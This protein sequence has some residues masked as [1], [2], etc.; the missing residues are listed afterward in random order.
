MGKEEGIRKKLHRS[1]SQT[2]SG[3]TA[4][5][6]TTTATTMRRRNHS[7]ASTDAATRLRGLFQTTS[8]PTVSLEATRHHHLNCNS[9]NP[10]DSI[11]PPK[12]YLTVSLNP[13]I[14]ATNAIGHPH[15]VVH[16]R[17]TENS[18]DPDLQLRPLTSGCN[19]QIGSNFC[20]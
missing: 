2:G 6:T 16:R 8:L 1:I 7:D 13:A 18:T 15:I 14:H 19:I 9:P 4:K 3:P 17:S 12:I 20:L 10:S 5:P 11:Q